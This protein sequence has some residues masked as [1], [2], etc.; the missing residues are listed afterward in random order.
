MRPSTGQSTTESR[1][2]K[3][4]SKGGPRTT[5]HGVSPRRKQPKWQ[6]S[7]CRRFPSTSRSRSLSGGRQSSPQIAWHLFAQIV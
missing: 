3:G 7:F 6:P 2:C 1:G 4:R 5:C